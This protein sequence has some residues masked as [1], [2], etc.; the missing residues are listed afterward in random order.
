VTSR[1]LLVPALAAALAG[2]AVGPDYRAP[3][4][5]LPAAY[6]EGAGPAPV[7]A[8][9]TTFRDPVLDSLIR[10]AVRA[11]PD[12]RSAR[13]RV[14]EARARRG[15][16]AADRLPSVDASA[17]A[18]RTRNSSN[19]FGDPGGTS[20]LFEAGFDA[21][22]EIDLFGHAAR[23]VEAADAEVAASVEDRR[24]VLVSLL[25]ETAR[26]YVDL[27]GARRR[28]AL[29][30]ANLASQERTLELTRSKLEAGLASELD[31]ARAETL[32][33]TTAAAV[34]G[35]E[36]EARRAVHALSALL[37]LPPDALSAEL[38]ADAPLPAIPPAV[39]AGLPSDLLRRRP[40]VR[41]AERRLAAATARVGA[42]TADLYP[43]FT[44]TGALGLASEDLGDLVDSGSRTASIGG[45]L[46]WPILD[47]G[48]ASRAVEIR[49]AIEEQAATAW[50][51]AVLRA[52]REVEDA[53][54]TL[55]KERERRAS[56]AAAVDAARRA[57][58]LADR[59]W[60]SGRTDF[61]AVLDAERVLLAS[62]DALAE[63]DLRGAQGLVALY[64]ALGGGWEIE[65]D[66]AEDPPR[67]EPGRRSL[68]LAPPDPRAPIR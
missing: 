43:R 58:D 12:L 55:A 68:D 5:R 3:E 22:W 40:D 44:L 8:W 37:A 61:F 67:G 21:A 56:L 33:R 7:A 27:L 52:L 51:A 46:R 66:A 24:D 48:R 34:P 9:W 18:S 50:E 41:R 14:L 28:A 42:A 57:H 36:A 6:S 30:R 45:V 13:A 23:E 26:D 49:G 29:A 19:A 2:C 17:G 35:F 15:L 39:P 60:R 65:T 31:V 32:V 38:G 16:A 63:S 59:V 25:A 54:V 1:A 20:N 11:N 53:L 47:F 10:R 62:E 4:A 64:K